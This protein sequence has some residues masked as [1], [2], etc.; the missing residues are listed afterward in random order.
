[1]AV[2]VDVA[3]DDRGRL[4]AQPERRVGEGRPSPSRL[5][6]VTDAVFIDVSLGR[7]RGAR[8][9][10]AGVTDTVAIGIE[11]DS[12]GES[13]A[14]IQIAADSVPIRV[15]LRIVRAGV[16]GVSEAVPV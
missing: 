10:V 9:V 6:G 15:V 14:S 3:R 8:T 12:G 13:R 4:A 1:M 11:V 7:V 2:P 5:A 16:A